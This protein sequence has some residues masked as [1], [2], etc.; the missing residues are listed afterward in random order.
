MDIQFPK[1]DGF[2]PIAIP[3]HEKSANLITA[4]LYAVGKGP[5]ILID[6]G[7]KFP[8]TL[9]YLETQ[10]KAAGFGFN[11]IEKILLTHGH[12]DH[13]GLVKSIRKAANR[14]IECFL[15]PDDR[16]KVSWES[17]QNN[18]WGKEEE[19][20]L[21]RAGSPVN[22]RKK[23]QDRFSYFK[24]LADPL[25]DFSF[26]KDGDHFSNKD[27]DLTVIHTPGHSPGSCCFYESN[28]KILFTGD[29]IIKHITPNPFVELKKKFLN[30]PGYQALT[31]YLDSL[32][33]LKA[34]EPAFVFTGHGKP[35][36]NLSNLIA[37]YFKHYRQRSDLIEQ[38]LKKKPGPI[39]PLLQDIYPNMPKG[40]LFLAVSDLFSH[41]EDLLSK[42]RVRMIEPGPP[43]QYCVINY[44]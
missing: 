11:D 9:D 21:T 14:P 34:L 13:I 4:N 10:L 27:Y 35:I 6:A 38:V 12:V 39:Y 36:K 7:P 30:I 15:H 16:L 1:I 41:I 17:F 43:E 8:G 33:K 37:S 19:D 3:F 31:I 20:F 26:L 44:N 24:G 23:M 28:R 25:K 42:G 29:V 5:I 40:D 18:F 22:V 2:I 32:E